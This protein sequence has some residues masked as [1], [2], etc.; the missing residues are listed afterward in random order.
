MLLN[1]SKNLGKR[2]SLSIEQ[3]EDIKIITNVG[4]EKNE[5]SSSKYLNAWTSKDT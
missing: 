4:N 3:S 5:T 1:V 2:K